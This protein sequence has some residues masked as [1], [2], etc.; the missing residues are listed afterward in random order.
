MIPPI[1]PNQSLRDNRSRDRLILLASILAA[2]VVVAVVIILVRPPSYRYELPAAWD[3]GCLGSPEPKVIS[4]VFEAG[5]FSEVS[6]SHDKSRDS[7]WYQCS[8]EWNL[9]G[10]GGWHQRIDLKID[11]LDGDEYDDY[12]VTIETIRKDEVFKTVTVDEIAGF[13]SGY[14]A[15]DT[16]FNDFECRA[17]DSNLKVQLLTYGGGDIGG[18]DIAVE[19]YLAEVGAYIQEQLAR[20]DARPWRPKALVPGVSQG[21]T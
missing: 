19:E 7:R 1:S 13:D 6:I 3:D 16:G 15:A 20:L 4:E 9:E 12:D 14:C 10:I 21:S 18:T 17:V 11:V 2:A 8:W 5:P